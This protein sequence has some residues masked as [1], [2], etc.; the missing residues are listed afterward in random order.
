MKCGIRITWNRTSERRKRSRIC[1][2]NTSES[3]E[4]C[5]ASDRKTTGRLHKFVSSASLHG[6]NNE[7]LSEGP[8]TNTRPN[9]SRTRPNPKSLAVFQRRSADAHCGWLDDWNMG[10]VVRFYQL[11]RGCCHVC[12]RSFTFGGIWTNS[13]AVNT[14]LDH[15]VRLHT[16]GRSEIIT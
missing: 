1:P 4:G 14:D 6:N 7:I 8:S 13:K 16:V 11:K 5:F 9:R 3:M 12:H 2:P 15:R 10:W